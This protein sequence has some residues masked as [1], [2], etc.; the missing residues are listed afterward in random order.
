MLSKRR[1]SCQYLYKETCLP[2]TRKHAPKKKKN[3]WE[4]LYGIH[5]N[6]K[7]N[8]LGV[9]G[10]HSHGNEMC[11][12][13]DP[14]FWVLAGIRLVALVKGRCGGLLGIVASA[15]SCV[16]Q[17]RGSQVLNGWA[18]HTKLG[19]I[20]ASFIGDTIYKQRV[21]TCFTFYLSGSFLAKAGPEHPH[22]GQLFLQSTQ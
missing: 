1:D 4:T 7:N 22:R 12:N 10:G 8:T 13:T 18:G 16:F 19:K 9:G 15:A 3:S 6:N 5:S 21:I 14:L 11:F 2:L 17:L 20:A